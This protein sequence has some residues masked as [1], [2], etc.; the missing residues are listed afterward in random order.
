[1]RLNIAKTNLLVLEKIETL[2]NKY[3]KE[4]GDCIGDYLM[5][6]ELNT[7]KEPSSTENIERL[8]DQLALKCDKLLSAHREL[9]LDNFEN[10]TTSLAF[11]LENLSNSK[12]L[13]SANLKLEHY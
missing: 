2:T 8:I 13:N 11:D 9:L 7:T 1:M 6:V 4:L 5:L 3:F 10:F 12:I